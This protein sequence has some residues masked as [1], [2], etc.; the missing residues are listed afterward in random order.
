MG[1]GKFA[2][3]YFD[4][5]TGEKK[6]MFSFPDNSQKRPHKVIF[7][8]IDSNLN[9]FLCFYDVDR[10]KKKIYI[11]L[12]TGIVERLDDV[13]MLIS[14]FTYPNQNMKFL[15]YDANKKFLTHEFLLSV[16]TE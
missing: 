14:A 6:M 15:I 4:L 1:V 16:Q 12:D 13:M 11:P 8:D 7:Q 10:R 2:D 3:V 5:L 9:G